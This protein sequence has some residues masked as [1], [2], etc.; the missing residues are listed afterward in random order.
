MTYEI[1]VGENSTSLNVTHDEEEIFSTVGTLSVVN[2]GKITEF[3][4]NVMEIQ[5]IQRIQ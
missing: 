2:Q 1:E 4:L 3:F 5:R